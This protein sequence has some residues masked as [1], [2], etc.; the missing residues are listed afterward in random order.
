[1]SYRTFSILNNLKAAWQLFSK[2]WLLLI[3]ILLARVF[4]S[5]IQNIAGFTHSAALEGLVGL[6][7]LV[8]SLLLTIATIIVPLRLVDGKR[9]TTWHEA[10]PTLRQTLSFIGATALFGLLMLA[11]IAACGFGCILFLRFTTNLW[12][13]AAIVGFA[14]V[15]GLAGLAATAVVYGF[16]GYALIERDLG[17]VAA[18]EES[19]RITRGRR[20]KVLLWILSLLG[21]NLVG[22]LALGVGLLVSFPMTL[23]S[24][25]L[26]YRTLSPRS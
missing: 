21:I 5:L 23:A 12:G 24:N 26:L 11:I 10:M 15:V 19:A 3:G 13:S 6:L 18:L 25:A 20:F 1:M 22:T 8:P 16:Y 7:I 4:L 9:V 17:P 14:A 2:H